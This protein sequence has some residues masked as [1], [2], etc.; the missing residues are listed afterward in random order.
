[1]KGDIVTTKNTHTVDE[2]EVA[3]THIADLS[4]PHLLRWIEGPEAGYFREESI[5]KLCKEDGD[6]QYVVSVK[7]NRSGIRLEG[8]PVHFKKGAHRSIV[9]EGLVPGTIQVPGDGMPIIALYER[10]NGGYARV[11]VVAGVD[12][13]RLAHLKPRDRVRFQ[14]ITREEA[15][16]LSQMRNESISALHRALGSGGS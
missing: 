12:A 15:L 11:G 1:M 8:E 2:K 9:S 14:R 16:E 6:G 7:S 5:R 4:P 13:D 10:M 3:S